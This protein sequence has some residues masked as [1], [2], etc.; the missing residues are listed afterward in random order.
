MGELLLYTNLVKE[1]RPDYEDRANY[2]GDHSCVVH[3]VA[4]V[5]STTAWTG[6]NPLR[7]N[8]VPTT[9]ALPQV[10]ILGHPQI[11]SLICEGGLEDEGHKHPNHIRKDE[12]QD[13]YHQYRFDVLASLLITPCPDFLP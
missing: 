1:D 10:L 4:T 2:N 6:F 3:G 12:A 7:A 11:R 9:L 5:R 13:D 8:G